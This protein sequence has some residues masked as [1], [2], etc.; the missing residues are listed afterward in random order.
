[1]CDYDTG[2]GIWML[3]FGMG[4]VIIVCVFAWFDR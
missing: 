1:M 3:G 2:W 4:A